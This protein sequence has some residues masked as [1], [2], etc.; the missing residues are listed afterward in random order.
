MTLVLFTLFGACCTLLAAVG[1]AFFDVS[2]LL[3]L[4]IYF[5]FCAT[6]VLLGLILSFVLP[7]KAMDQHA[8]SRGSGTPVD[9]RNQTGHNASCSQTPLV[10]AVRHT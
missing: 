5:G 9:R 8:E 2:V 10:A 3:V 6:L 4:Q 1:I 7:H